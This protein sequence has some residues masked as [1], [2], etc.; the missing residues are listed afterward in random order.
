[1]GLSLEYY[2]SLNPKQYAKHCKIYLKKE[3]QDVKVVDRL[4]H[5]LG[6]YVG[7]AVNNGKEYPQK[8]YLDREETK[9]VEPQTVEDM[10]KIAR[11]NTL[12][13]G[14]VINDDRGNT[15]TNNG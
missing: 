15:S 12:C 6:Q 11:L 9:Q 1:M 5:I 4:N 7:I 2:W 13:L 10:E 14:G 8:P 3:E